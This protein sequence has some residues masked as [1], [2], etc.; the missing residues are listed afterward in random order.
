MT[1]LRPSREKT[2]SSS[3]FR[4]LNL[5]SLKSCASNLLIATITRWTPIS[6]QIVKWRSVCVRIPFGASTKTSAISARDA[7]T[8]IFLVY[9]S[10][11]GA[12]EIMSRFP[13]N[14]DIDR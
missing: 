12:S 3:L 14:S 7:A 9:S 4:A 1:S 13:F 8:A 10:C 5:S 6:A 2:G 11:P